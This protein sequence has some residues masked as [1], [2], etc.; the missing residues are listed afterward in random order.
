MYQKGSKF[1]YNNILKI[2]EK[3]AYKIIS[4]LK[5]LIKKNINWREYI[6]IYFFKNNY[7]LSVKKREFTYFILS[8][9][10]I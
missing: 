5:K 8:S 7:L 3:I 9:L 10:L 1:I 6:K 4:Q 2:K